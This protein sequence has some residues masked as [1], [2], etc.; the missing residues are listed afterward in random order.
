M[1]ASPEPSAH[2]RPALTRDQLSEVLRVAMRAGQLMLENG[3]NTA[4]VEETV[5]RLGTALGAE[6]LDVYVTPSG[7]IASATSHGEHRTI[8]QRVVRSGIDLSRIAAVLAVS[9]QAEEGGLGGPAVR[10]QLETIASQP[11]VYGRW[12]TALAVAIGCGC[13]AALFGASLAESGVAVLAAGVAQLA[14]EQLGRLNLS[15]LLVTGA[16]AGLA[17]GLALLIAPLLGVQPALPLLAAVLLLVPGVLM[18][19]SVA[20]LFRGDTISGLARAANAFLALGA[21]SAGIW[22]ALLVSG[23][24]AALAPGSPPGLLW[25]TGYATLAAAGFAVLFDVPKRVIA[26]SAL[27]GGLAF[28]ARQ[29]GL[30]AQLPA[31]AAIFISGI[32][33][34]ALAELLARGLRQPAMLFTI[35]GFIPLVP[36][37]AAFR[38]LLEFVN[39]DYGAGTAS[40]VRTALLTSA[41]AAGLGIPSALARIRQK[42]LF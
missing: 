37:S 26:V 8:T 5:H 6:W 4:R 12:A 35:P 33:I 22:T 27:V 13:F 15:R 32:V 30:A 42:P 23:V 16:V 34:G 36:G 18:V 28:A 19:S 21:I 2:A 40:F 17:S 25:A 11:R 14:R 9:R 38:T 7:I 1:I 39:G 29:L 41:L 24:P 20:D 10:A 31:E 3:A